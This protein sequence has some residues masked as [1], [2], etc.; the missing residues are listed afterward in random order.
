MDMQ[1]IYFLPEDYDD[2]DIDKTNLGA[3]LV[4]SGHWDEVGDANQNVIDKCWTALGDFFTRRCNRLGLEIAAEKQ[5]LVFKPTPNKLFA[6]AATRD[7]AVKSSKPDYVCTPGDTFKVSDEAEKSSIEPCRGLLTDL[8]NS[9]EYSLAFTWKCQK[10]YGPA[11]ANLQRLL[12]REVSAAIPSSSSSSDPNANPDPKN[13]KSST[14]ANSKAD[15]Q[16]KGLP[17]PYHK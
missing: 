1:S 11:N 14:K 8:A 15:S 5:G 16:K 6:K 3:Y 17:K 12:A 2:V 4:A 13:T 9:G 10:S 7:R